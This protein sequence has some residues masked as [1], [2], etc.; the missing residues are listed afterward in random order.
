MGVY[1]YVCQ[2]YMCPN[3]SAVLC[4]GCIRSVSC[5]TLFGLLLLLL[6]LLLLCI[7]ASWVMPVAVCVWKG[8]DRREWVWIVLKALYIRF[9]AMVFVFWGVESYHLHYLLS[10]VQRYLDNCLS[11]D[12]Y[13]Y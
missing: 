9:T 1:L 10:A 2:E 8:R 7:G 3:G 13:T 5:V 4:M 11:L 6:M 12:L